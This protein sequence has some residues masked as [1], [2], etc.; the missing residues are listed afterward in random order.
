MNIAALP[1]Q[2]EEQLHAQVAKYLTIACPRGGDVL[3]YHCPNGASLAG[4]LKQRCAQMAKLKSLGL[5]AGVCDLVFIWRGADLRVG[6]IEL[7]RDARQKLS[8]AQEWFR[9]WCERL[10]I[11][12][13]VCWSLDTVEGTLR[14][15]AVPLKVTLRR[16]S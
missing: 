11:P 4:N 7:K 13:A 14:R 12:H 3:W 16:A 2:T 1:L 10:G 15:W 9:L 8:T 6:F 5:L